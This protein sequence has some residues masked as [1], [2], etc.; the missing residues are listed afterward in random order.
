MHG[1]DYVIPGDVKEVAPM[2]LAH[3]L[4]LNYDAKMKEMNA[5][6][7]VEDI[8]LKLKEPGIQ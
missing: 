2:T 8:L 3:R 5:L 1:R 4:I 7:I 6:S